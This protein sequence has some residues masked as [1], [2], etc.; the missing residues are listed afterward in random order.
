ME[1]KELHFE[2]AIIQLMQEELGYDYVYGPD[3]ERK[4]DEPF[5]KSMVESSLRNVNPKEPDAAIAEAL[6]A[7]RNIENGPLAHRN[8]IFMDYL[9]NGIEVSYSQNGEQKSSLVR[10]VDYENIDRNSFLLANQWTFV[11]YAERR[12]DLMIFINGLPLVM[13]ELKSPSRENTDSS[14][15]YRQFRNNMQEI[16]SLFVYNAILVMSDMAETKAGTI[17]ASEDRFMKWKTVD[18][19]YENTQYAD[20]STLFKG[21]FEKKRLLD[22]I[23]NF[24]CFSHEENVDAK[25]LAGYHQYFAVRKAIE[26]TVKAVGTDGK[27][28]V[29]WHTHGSGKSLSMVFYA[30]LLQE[31]LNSPT[32][33]VITDRNDLDD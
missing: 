24:I 32:I 2:N 29:F 5:V 1:Y 17:T 8:S 26:T 13:I 16:P 19:D 15:A 33:V 18:G 30:R 11:E 28:G 23:R 25:I 12:P 3:V 31:A 10:L 22:I 14:E 6:Y 20:W 27:G 7:L 9:Q 4:Y 21:M